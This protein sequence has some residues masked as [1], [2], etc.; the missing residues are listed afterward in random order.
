MQDIIMALDPG[1]TSGAAVV[2]M[3][4][5]GARVLET[6]EEV[7]HSVEEEVAV[8]QRL[9]DIAHL[10]GCTHVVIEDFVLVPG[11]AL[12]KVALVPV[13]LLAMMQFA[14]D[15]IPIYTQTA[16]QAKG[17]ITDA[18]LK[19]VGL[20]KGRSPHERDALRH[21][22]LFVRRLRHESDR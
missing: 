14:L 20:Y 13:R 18:R 15:D 10:K 19:D 6:W 8:V 11:A 9:C 3:R 5:S 4:Q 21:A 22:L 16:S 2:Q 7:A 17:V 12:K 1:S